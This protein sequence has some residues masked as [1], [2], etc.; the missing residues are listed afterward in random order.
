[1]ECKTSRQTHQRG[2]TFMLLKTRWSRAPF[3]LVLAALLV[4]PAGAQTSSGATPDCYV[5]SV[6]VDGY[7]RANPLKGC[8]NDARDIAAQFTGQ[9]GKMFGKVT[10][11]VLT[12]T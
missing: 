12:E 1:M 11:R 9:Q 6:G 10:S 5:L 7:A 8:V 3:A 2:A 4:R